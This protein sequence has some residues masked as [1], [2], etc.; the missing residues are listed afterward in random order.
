MVTLCV[1]TY[2]VVMKENSTDTMEIEWTNECKAHETETISVCMDIQ[3]PMETL[4]ILLKEKTKKDLSGYE[5]RLQNF[6]LLQ[7]CETLVDKC[8]DFKGQVEINIQISHTLKRINIF[9]VVTK[10]T[11]EYGNFY[12]F[13]GQIKRPIS[14]I[15]V[16]NFLNLQLYINSESKTGE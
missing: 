15:Y 3:S 8:F 10:N 1:F 13:Q 5:V 16:N 12:M 6:E 14:V 2:T 7:T 4:K 11:I 9:D